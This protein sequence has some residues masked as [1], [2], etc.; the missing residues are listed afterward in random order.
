MNE[1]VIHPERTIANQM[2]E[3]TSAVPRHNF[4]EHVENL[5]RVPIKINVLRLHLF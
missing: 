1:L 3:Q 5:G 4:S 2:N